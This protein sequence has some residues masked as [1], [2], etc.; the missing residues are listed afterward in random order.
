[1]AARIDNKG[2]ADLTVGG[3]AFYNKPINGVVPTAKTSTGY[4]LGIRHIF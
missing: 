3:P 2:G 4:D 1:T